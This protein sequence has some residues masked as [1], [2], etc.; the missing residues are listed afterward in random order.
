MLTHIFWRIEQS[1]VLDDKQDRPIKASQA[2]LGQQV[3]KE[4]GGITDKLYSACWRNT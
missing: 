4:T 2:K 1:A 3:D